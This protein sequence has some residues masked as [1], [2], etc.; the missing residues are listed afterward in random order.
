ML[1][2]NAEAEF[3]HFLAGRGLALDAL[4]AS[5]AVAA[6]IGFYRDVRADDVDLTEDGDMLLFQ[7]GIY[8]WTDAP[9]T[10]QYDITRQLIAA[11]GD[12]DDDFGQLSLVVHFEPTP[13]MLDLR[14]GHE[15][16]RRPDDLPGFEQFI[17]TAEATICA[18]GPPA[19]VELVFGGV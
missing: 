17:A 3:A 8:S 10:F 12:D 9:E 14:S 15:W 13:P 18:A 4:S 2:V 11:G 16:C 6:M 19:R 5:T 7:W 1:A